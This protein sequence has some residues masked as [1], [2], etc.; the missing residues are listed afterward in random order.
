MRTSMASSTCCSA[1]LN[2]RLEDKQIRVEADRSG[3][4]LHRSRE[5]RPRLRRPS[6]PPVYPAHHRDPYRS[7]D[8]RRGFGARHRAHR[9]SGWEHPLYPLILH[10]VIRCTPTFGGLPQ[11]AAPFLSGANRSAPLSTLLCYATMTLFRRILHRLGGVF[12]V[13]LR[14]VGSVSSLAAP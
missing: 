14:P 4:G 6:P 2:K 8:H 11:L 5:L 3:Q 1:G 7:E 13:F 12:Y 10:D 9:G